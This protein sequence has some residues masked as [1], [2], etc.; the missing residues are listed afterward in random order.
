[1][2]F[3]FARQLIK[4]FL[5]YLCLFAFCR[6]V[7]LIYFFK[8]V[9]AEGWRF[10]FL[11]FL[12]AIPLDISAV[13]YLL[14]IPLLLITAVCI[15][16]KK[17]FLLLLKLYIALTSF[18]IIFLSIA[19][20]GVYREVHV[21]V[22]FNLLSHL[23]HA[24][25]LFHSVSL[26]LLF[27]LLL[28]IALIFSGSIKILN[29]LFPFK[30]SGSEPSVSSILQ[31]LIAFLL[32]IPLLVLGCRGGLQPIAINE[33]EVY[34]SNNQCVNDATVNPLWNLVHS[35]IETRK[36]L[37]NNT[38]TVMPVAEAN[39]IVAHL[40]SVE[41][42]TTVSLFKIQR[43]NVCFLILESWSAEL[44]QSLGGYQGLTPNFEKLIKEG[45]LF[46][47]IEAT[48]HVSDQ[49]IPGI[50]SGYPAL[51]IGSAINQPGKNPHLPCINKQLK[52]AGYNSSFFFGGQL[53]YGNIKS[54]IY[55]NQFD[56]VLEQ[57]DLPASIP[58]GRLGIHDSTML[59]LWS[60]SLNQMKPPFFSCLFTLSTHSP[61][62]AEKGK[63]VNWGTMEDNYLGSAI[64]SDRQIG[65]FFEMAK[66]EPWYDSTIFIIV[67]DHSHS[68]P[69][70]YD[71]CTPEFYHIPLL[72]TG[73]ALKDEYR[74]S[75]DERIGSQLDIASTL[76]HQLHLNSEAYK[77]SKNLL[78]PYTNRFAFFTFDEGFGLVEPKGNI[79]WNK[80]FPATNRNT[81][82]TE[83]EK[84]NL[85][86][87]GHAMLQVLVDDFLKK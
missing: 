34:F 78:N 87:H 66:K 42:D 59:S 12:K 6:A 13:C 69:K 70:N 23:N 25:E 5:Y 47:S 26:P 4:V 65:R 18:F 50:L 61:F 83:E 55:Y 68:T 64:Y 71:Y 45:Y 21:K 38:Y 19:E 17:I 73:G 41:K 11:S 54:Y 22:Y 40:Y 76:L 62:D 58:A 20:I 43:P 51:P 15:W 29:T 3:R 36:I 8:E 44:I 63:A 2:L 56:R 27:T 67:A 49:G 28:L 75:K 60:D 37:N 9:T 14:F 79:V 10:F 48:G 33:G 82:H 30:H 72:I 35:Y 39:Q 32:V 77:W 57:A 84:K 52:E 86:K 16:Q 46:S 85:D 7:F 74:G 81:G 24:D 31:I 53:I 80:K 1:M